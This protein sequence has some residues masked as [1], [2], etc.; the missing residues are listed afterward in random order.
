MMIVQALFWTLLGL[1]V[2]AYFGFPLLLLIRGVLR[3]PVA[4]SQITPPMTL[5]IAAHNEV[6]AI[7]EKIDNVLA[8]DYPAE[9][10]E[11]IIASDGSDDGTNDL[12]LAYA[13][14][15]VRLVDQP[16]Q[17]KVPTLNAGV[18]EA[19]GE[20]LVFTDANSM[21]AK[22]TLSALASCFADENVG[23]V[24]GDQ[25]YSLD[26]GNTA[27][28]GERLY[29]SFDR[30]LKQMQSNAGNATCST[31][32]I[33]AIRRE[34]FRPVPSGVSDDFVISTRAIEQ[35]YRLVFEPDA[36][37]YEEVA[38]TDGAEFRRKSR[39][40]ARGLRGLWAV[41]RLFNPFKYGFYSFQLASHKLLRWSVIWLMPAVL[42]LS[43]ILA[44][45]GLVYQILAIA[46]GVFYV[47]ALLGFVL[48]NA[49]VSRLRL[50]KVVAVPF[51][52]CLANFAAFSGWW[53]CFVGRRVDIWHSNRMSETAET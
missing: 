36:I 10:L 11:V 40:I 29:W 19:T 39:V 30:W 31:G 45:S 14:Q 15:N 47:G 53:Q 51:Y 2:Y 46:Q 6:R 22:A 18:A 21:L 16:R 52:F 33:H 17:G 9:R 27:S 48:R 35:G 23:A 7:G 25:R 34:L 38:P 12:V 5:V 50:F 3:R 20:I 26:S 1:I 41:R 49:S 4:K 42:I 8:L 28:F 43:L 44:G 13:D 37:A 24:A 32:A